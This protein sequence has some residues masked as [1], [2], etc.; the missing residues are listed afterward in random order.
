[1]FRVIAALALSLAVTTADASGYPF[2]PMD[3]GPWGID[4]YIMN[5]AGAVPDADIKKVKT[6]SRKVSTGKKDIEKVEEVKN[7]ISDELEEAEE[8]FFHA[9]ENVEDVIIHAIDDEVEMLFPHHQ[10]SKDK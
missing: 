2:M 7:N 4:P 9:V 8:A 3:L 1:M 5:T 10:K 6:T